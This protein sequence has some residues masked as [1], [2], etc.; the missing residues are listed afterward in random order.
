MRQN[1]LSSKVTR[2]LNA[3]SRSNKKSKPSELDG[4]LRNKSRRPNL[5]QLEDRRLMAVRVWDGGAVSNNWTNAT[6]WVSNIAPTAGDDL[7]FPAGNFDKTTDN[8]FANGTNFQ[9]ITL[10]GGYTL[11]GNRIFLGSGGLIDNSGTSNIIKNDLDLGAA[12]AI[13]RQLQV[14]A[15]STLF[16]DGKIQGGNGLSKRGVG[17]LSL[18]ANNEYGG[19]TDVVAGILFIE[20]DQ[21][22][23]STSAGTQVLSGATLLFNDNA[24]GTLRVDEPMTLAA[25]AT[26]RALNDVELNGNLS[27]LGTV[28][29]KQESSQLLSHLAINS[30]ISGAGGVV[31]ASGGVI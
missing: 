9:S 8:D 23:G 24:V 22:L 28:T 5:E 30:S 11:R 18:R 2:L 27:L 31:V 1:F 19:L 4:R 17:N 21:S 13:P 25:G 3:L 20:K 15:G 16:I 14:G 12:S 7:V 29:L 10:G 6:N 26:L